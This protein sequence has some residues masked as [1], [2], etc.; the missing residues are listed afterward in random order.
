MLH[1]FVGADLDAVR[2]TV[3]RPF[4][5]YLK[6][7]TDLV[8]QARWEFPAF[9]QPG[10]DRAGDAAHAADASDLT[11]A[12]LDAMMDHAFDAVLPDERP[13]RHAGHLPSDGGD[14]EGDWRRRDRVPRRLRRRRRLGARRASRTSIASA[15][16]ARAP[17]GGRP[18]AR[19]T[20]RRRSAATASPTCS[21]RRRSP[22]CSPRAKARS[23]RSRPLRKLLLG[24]EALPPAL[25]AAAR[26]GRRR[27]HRQ[28]VRADGDDG[29]VDDVARRQARRGASRLGGRSRT[30]SSTCSTRAGHPSR[31]AR[32]ASSSSAAPASSA[33]ISG[34]PSSPRERFVP[35][36][37]SADYAAR[38]CTGRAISSVTG[39][40]ET[41]SSSAGSITR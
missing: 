5:E 27:R 23:P 19:G 11:P 3:R 2:E 10:K 8:R 35:S 28:H 33:A 7:S 25:A 15:C 34:G 39:P 16:G 31:L 6:T 1:T 13:L 29:M 17:R 24:G 12:E 32:P 41:S 21:A 22:A 30:P 36:P 4:T 26:R 38:A 37:F 40:T 18:A 14:P 20:S 9:A